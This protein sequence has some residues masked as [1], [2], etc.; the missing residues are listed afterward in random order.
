MPKRIIDVRVIAGQPTDGSGQISIHLFVRD[1]HGKFTEPA[2]VHPVFKDGVRQ[3]N[4][5]ACLPTRGRLACDAD[6]NP[7]AQRVGNRTLVTPRTDDPR[8]VTCPKCMATD[9]Y[10]REMEGLGG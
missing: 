9:A 5:T 2:V 10:R 1:P 8:A 7:A 3:G 4:Q 6:R